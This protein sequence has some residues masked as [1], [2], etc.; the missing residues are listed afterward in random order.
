MQPH[1]RAG[2]A[3]LV[4]AIEQLAGRLGHSA[5]ST[6]LSEQ[7]SACRRR[8]RMASTSDGARPRPAPPP[9]R[10]DARGPLRGRAP[11]ARP[12]DS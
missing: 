10:E 2:R 1:V 8:P 4:G 5:S 6:E 7:R 12:G 9:M 11:A 3:G